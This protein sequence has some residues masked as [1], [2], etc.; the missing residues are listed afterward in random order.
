MSTSPPAARHIEQWLRF[1][2]ELADAAHALLAPAAAVRPAVQVKADR[3]FVTALDA[4][5][6]TRLREMIAN[7]SS[8]RRCRAS[9]CSRS[10]RRKPPPSAAS[11]SNAGR[12]W[13]RRRGTEP[14][15]E[16]A[17]CGLSFNA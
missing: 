6:E 2:H 4:Q 14:A 16:A 1:A 8:C 9:R 10:T 15:C 13:R 11:S 17:S 7:M 3:S 5:I 12:R